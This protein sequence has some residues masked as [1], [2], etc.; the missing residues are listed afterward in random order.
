MKENMNF[1]EINTIKEEIKEMMPI[2]FGQIYQKDDTFLFKLKQGYYIRV[3][4]PSLIYLSHKKENINQ[5]G[6]FALFLRRRIKG[7][8]VKDVKQLRSERILYF[9]LI[10]KGKVFF[11]YVE[12]FSKGN[13]V[14][15]DEDKIILGA[16]N[17]EVRGN[18]FKKGEKYTLENQNLNLFE[19]T[20]KDFEDLFEGKEVFEIIKSGFGKVLAHEITSDENKSY[21]EQWQEVLERERKGLQYLEEGNVKSF[22]PVELEYFSDLEK[23]EFKTLSAALDDITK[24]FYDFQNRKKKGLKHSLEQQKKRIGQIDKDVESHKKKAKFL[25]HNYQEIDKLLRQLN[26]KFKEGGKENLID[27]LKSMDI[28]YKNINT[29]EKSLIIEFNNEDD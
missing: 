17:K 19:L 11:L 21:Y 10:S 16:Y 24:E 4:L 20:K 6:N 23:K 12:L 15:T 7:A 29:K 27:F 25:Y 2:R 26:S 13:I 18:S 1:L 14:L 8:Y 9:K 22:S 5:S 3:I 28:P